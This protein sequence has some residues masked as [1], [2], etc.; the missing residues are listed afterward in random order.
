[1]T[2]PNRPENPQNPADEAAIDAILD[3]DGSLAEVVERDPN[4]RVLAAIA[5]VQR[6]RSKDSPAPADRLRTQATAIDGLTL[7][8][9][10]GSGAFGEVL[11]AHDTQLR[12]DVAVKVLS[13]DADTETILSEGRRLARVRHPNVVTVY[14][15]NRMPDGIA[16][17]MEFVDGETLADIVRSSGPL[18]AREVIRIGIALCGA[19]AA[20]HAAGLLHRD[21]KAQNVMRERHTGRIVLMDFG[22]AFAR[23]TYGQAHPAA[24][25]PLYTAPE[26]WEGAAPSQRTD[27]YSVGVLLFFL[28]SASFPLIADDLAALRVAHRQRKYRALIDLNPQVPVA[29]ASVVQKAIAHNAAIRFADADALADALRR[30]DAAI[31]QPAGRRVR[32]GLTTALIML[33]AGGVFIAEHLHSSTVRGTTFISTPTNELGHSVSRDGRLWPF[34]TEAGTLRLL[35][36]ATGRTRELLPTPEDGVVQSSLVSP[37]GDRVAYTVKANDGS[38][39]LETIGADGSGMR[40]LIA[41]ESSYEPE[42]ISWSNDRAL[43]LCWLHQRNGSLDLAAVPATRE[44][45]RILLIRSARAE[46]GASLS[47]DGRFAAVEQWRDPETPATELLAVPTDGSPPVSLYSDPRHPHAPLWAPDNEHV[48]FL[49]DSAAI[50]GSQDG[51]VLRV[52]SGRPQGRPTLV[53]RN[54]G[55]GPKIAE[56][57]TDRQEL[58]S[59]VFRVTSEVYLRQVDLPTGQSGPPTR[60]S[61]DVVDRHAGASF[62]PDGRSIAYFTLDDPPTVGANP[63]PALTI[64]DRATHRARR[65]TLS[66]T[67]LGYVQPRWRHDSGALC[68]FGRDTADPGR[69]GYYEIDLRTGAVTPIV[70]LKNWAGSHDGQWGRDDEHFVYPDSTRGLIERDLVTGT[71]TTLVG[72]DR[73][74]GWFAIGPDGSIAFV[75]RHS[76]PRTIQVR[77]PDGSLRTLLTAP[78]GA[79]VAVHAWSADGEY[80]LFTTGGPDAVGSLFRVPASGGVPVDLRVRWVSNP[81]QASISPDSREIAVTETSVDYELRF[82]PLRFPD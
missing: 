1:M 66:M 62:S 40:L 12:R 55:A 79:N 67:Y 38:Y 21:V 78:P 41:S 33:A 8:A 10:I 37:A 23:E 60:I 76:N 48:F 19:V 81:N 77:R 45:P 2:E 57:L 7:I 6:D 32:T 24:G 35:D 47:P 26:L 43:M 9:P 42:P 65:L 11:R 72:R 5:A 20:V 82:L 70:L 30:A 39:R 15:V 69:M 73:W 31:R 54:L 17:E 46:P 44:P 74:S 61:A 63:R 75:A 4:L 56:A 13:F 14:G 50:P 28:L 58:V 52:E 51:W 80:V 29:L 16:L 49:M 18:S 59:R 27:L 71:E 64:A 25:T 22:A 34:A 68:V 53:A 3:G 36:A